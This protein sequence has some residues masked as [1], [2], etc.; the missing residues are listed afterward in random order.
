VKEV[1]RYR[2]SVTILQMVLDYA[3]VYLSFLLG[4]KFYHVVGLDIGLGRGPQPFSIYYRMFFLAAGIYILIFER[5]GLYSQKG[6]VLNIG[7]LKGMLQAQLVS[8]MVMFTMLFYVR[9]ELQP[10]RLIVSY[11]LVICFV[12]VY[13]QRTLV[14]RIYQRLQLK[15]RG[16]VRVLIYGAGEVGRQVARRLLQ[17]PRLGMKPV[18]FLDDDETKHGSSVRILCDVS[19]TNIEVLGGEADLDRL[20]TEFDIDEVIIAMPSAR[21]QR[22][23]QL[24]KAC[25]ERKIAFSFVPNLFDLLLQK[26][27]FED[28]DGVPMLRQKEVE[29]RYFYLILKRIFDICFSLVVLAVFAVFLPVLAY[30]IRRDSPGPVFFVQ[31]R[32][33]KDGRRFKMYKLRTMRVDAPKYSLTPE[34][35]DDPRITRIGRILRHYS[36][37]EIP[38]FLN[39]LKGDMSV[40]GPRPEMPFLV[41]QYTPAQQVRLR[42]RPG[43]T[44]IWQISRDRAAQIHDNI[45]YDLY[46]A[47]NQSFL[48]DLIIILKTI[49]S[50]IHGYGAI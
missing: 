16:A 49:T 7:E 32:V 35:P 2:L 37:D 17:S 13:L 19:S 43:I 36:I 10:S 8:A 40:V 11:S 27:E 45:D 38:Q 48:L 14:Y 46:Y 28:L 30:L 41:E 1:R 44:G 20:I 22:I 26:V 3:T 15:T 50:A 25:S 23:Y 47:E 39:V 24:V 6:T 4:Y 9:T 34:S 18:G 29:V 21:P 5:F 31:E 33:G 12:L 42:V